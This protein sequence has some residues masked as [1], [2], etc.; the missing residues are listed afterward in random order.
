MLTVSL[1]LTSIFIIGKVIPL[2]FRIFITIVALI[3]EI[4]CFMTLFMVIGLFGAFIFCLLDFLFFKLL[5]K[6]F[7]I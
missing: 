2:M 1:L 6:M 4:V 3:L 5:S 7:F